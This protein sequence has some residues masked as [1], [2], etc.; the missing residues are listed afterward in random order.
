MY[1]NTKRINMDY[2]MIKVDTDTH[3]KIKVQAYNSG[4]NIMEYMKYLADTDIS[5]SEAT[6]RSLVQ[7]FYEKYGEEF[8]KGFESCVEMIFADKNNLG[9]GVSD[10]EYYDAFKHIEVAED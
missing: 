2:K 4:R 9:S 5:E 3:L 10:D 8:G 1:T 6:V 7:V